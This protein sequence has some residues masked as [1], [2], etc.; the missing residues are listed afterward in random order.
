MFTKI[1]IYYMLEMLVSKINNTA[2]FT[3]L[4]DSLYHKWFVR[5]IV[6]P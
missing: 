2:G 6:Q 1:Q 5:G 3:T 4:A